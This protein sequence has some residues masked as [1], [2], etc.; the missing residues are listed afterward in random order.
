VR[1]LNQ[2]LDEHIYNINMK[3]ATLGPNFKGTVRANYNR[4]KVVWVRE[5]NVMSHIP[6]GFKIDRFFLEVKC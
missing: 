3:C 4:L 2:L 1:F 6:Y 5:G